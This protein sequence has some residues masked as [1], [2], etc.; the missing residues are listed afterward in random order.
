MFN[1]VWSSFWNQVTDKKKIYEVDKSTFFH[2]V[3]LEFYG[4]KPNGKITKEE[5]QIV[6]ELEK[7]TKEYNKLFKLYNQRAEQYTQIAEQYTPS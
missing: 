7:G 5:Q 2:Y 3:V 6:R 1:L 4:Y